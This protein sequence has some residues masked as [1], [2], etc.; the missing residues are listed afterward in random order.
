MEL[1]RLATAH[2]PCRGFEARVQFVI[3]AVEEAL[4]H[5]GAEVCG[6]ASYQGILRVRS[7]PFRLEKA[8]G[9]TH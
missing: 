5:A 6:N 4:K 1:V 9:V 7:A 2:V 8:I 3:A